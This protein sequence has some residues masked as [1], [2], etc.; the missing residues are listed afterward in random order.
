M[1]QKQQQRL[2]QA[3]QL[4]A[5]HRKNIRKSSTNVGNANNDNNDNNNVDN[6]T[7]NIDATFDDSYLDRKASYLR[8]VTKHL[9]DDSVY[10]DPNNIQKINEKKERIPTTTFK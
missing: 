10:D 2:R 1:L 9:N 6:N 7:S 3:H 4:R 5:I 8:D